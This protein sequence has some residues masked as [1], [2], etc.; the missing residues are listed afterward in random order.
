MLRAAKK[1]IS[2]IKNHYR[3]RFHPEQTRP[4]LPIISLQNFLND[5]RNQSTSE[6]MINPA[7]ATLIPKEIK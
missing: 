7:E 5:L 2:K 6:K 4:P 1:N 3:K